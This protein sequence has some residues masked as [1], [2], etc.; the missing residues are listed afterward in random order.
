MLNL[1]TALCHVIYSYPPVTRIMSHV[2][3]KKWP[4]H[5]VEFKGQGP[6]YRNIWEMGGPVGSLSEPGLAGNV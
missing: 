3:F 4:C 5:T 6:Y 1:R 2:D